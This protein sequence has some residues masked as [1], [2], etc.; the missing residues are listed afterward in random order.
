M[1][2]GLKLPTG[3]SDAK[4]TTHLA[5]GS[6]AVR[7][8]DESIQPGDGLFGFSLGT[9]MFHPAPLHTY[10]YFTGSWTFNP[11]GPTGVLTYRSLKGEQVISSQDQYLWRGGFSRNVPRIRG[12]AFSAGGRM[13]GVPVRNAFGS[14]AGFRRPGYVISFEPGVM[15]TRNRYSLNVS[16]PWAIERNRKRSIN[17][18]AA[19]PAVHGDAAFSDYTIIASLSRRF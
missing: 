15:Y 11:F 6:T 5:N 13:E 8:F 16:G 4:G 1:S 18:I 2:F 19:G 9:V 14:S 7:P 12:L 10:A 3:V 17:D